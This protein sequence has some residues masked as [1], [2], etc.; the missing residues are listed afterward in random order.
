M[1]ITARLLEF[2][3]TDAL[4]PIVADPIVT[5]YLGFK[6]IM[7]AAGATALIAG[8]QKDVAQWFGYFAEGR[9]VGV[10]GIERQGHSVAIAL[11]FGRNVK[12]FGRPVGSAAVAEAFKDP[13]IRRV[14]AHCHTENIPV[15]R[16]L[17]R[18][19]AKREGRLRKYAVFPNI[20]DEPQDCYIYS[21]VQ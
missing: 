9:L 14:W 4:Y 7:T 18:M 17:E 16:V 6:T 21:I 1:K 3:D 5:R 8:Y 2:S 11:Y 10:S 20:S 12:G 13:T 19:G 15:Q